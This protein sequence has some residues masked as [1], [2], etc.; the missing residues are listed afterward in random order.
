M[1]LNRQDSTTTKRTLAVPETV[2]LSTEERIEF[3]AKLIVERIVEDENNGF[4]LLGKIK[5]SY[6]IQ[7]KIA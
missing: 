4:L 1:S 5:A 6:G 7:Q 3:I 2:L